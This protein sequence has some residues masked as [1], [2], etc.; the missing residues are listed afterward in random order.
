[1]DESK[2]EIIIVG[3]SSTKESKSEIIQKS[4]NI[5]KEED[6]VDETD[7]EEPVTEKIVI[8]E[9]RYFNLFECARDLKQI[10]CYFIHCEN[11]WFVAVGL[12]IPR[13]AGMVW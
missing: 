1:M 5:N 10:H 6:S 2:S 12:H 7:H 9:P 13:C 11:H 8:N 4:I 3:K